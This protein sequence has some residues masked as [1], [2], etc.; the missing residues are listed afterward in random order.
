MTN[1]VRATLLFATLAVA[2]SVRGQTPIR[3]S[4][5][6]ALALPIGDLGDAANVGF[7]LGLRGEGKLTSSPTWGLRGDLTWDHF[8]GKG[9]VD[10]YS[11]VALAGNLLHRSAGSRVYQYGGLGIYGSRTAFIDRLSRDETNLGLQGGVGVDFPGKGLN[12]FLEFGLTSV[13][14]SG[15]NS[16]WFPL[17]FGI[18]F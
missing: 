17:R 4:A 18:R 13:V 3:F 5:A 2:P 11:F 10:S 1:C 7:H 16:L 12:P 8:G 6:A 9:V 15:S 14:T